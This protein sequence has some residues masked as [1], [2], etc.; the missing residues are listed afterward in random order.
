MSFDTIVKTEVNTTN[1]RNRT[2]KKK[3]KNMQDLRT[4]VNTINTNIKKEERTQG[5]IVVHANHLGY[6]HVEL[7]QKRAHCTSLKF[8]TPSMTVHALTYIN[9]CSHTQ[10]TIL[11]VRTRQKTERNPKRGTK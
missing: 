11:T 6:I 4:I 10:I 7:R 2:K 8:N 1:Q 5:I 9:I 3:T